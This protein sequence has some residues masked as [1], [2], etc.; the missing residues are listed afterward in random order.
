M[1]QSKMNYFRSPTETMQIEVIGSIGRVF[2]LRRD[3]TASPEIAAK[4]RLGMDEDEDHRQDV[5]W[6]SFGAK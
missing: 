1:G 3:V 5:F 4:C 6:E 2:E